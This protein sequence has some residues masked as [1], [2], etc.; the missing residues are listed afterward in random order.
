MRGNVFSSRERK[1]RGIT[2]SLID[3]T[4]PED[5]STK[6]PFSTRGPGLLKEREKVS[7]MRVEVRR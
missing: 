5:Y 2:K 1:D 6:Q 7:K 3:D 4:L